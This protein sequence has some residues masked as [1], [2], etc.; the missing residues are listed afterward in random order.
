MATPQLAMH[1]KV[2]AFETCIHTMVPC[3]GVPP[4]T[5]TTSCS[6]PHST[7]TIL[8]ALLGNITRNDKRQAERIIK[9]ISADSRLYTVFTYHM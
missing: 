4:T 2:Q 7:A 9:S 6:H 1:M 5:A 8:T 3:G